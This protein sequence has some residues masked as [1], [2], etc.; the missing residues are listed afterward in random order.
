M[1]AYPRRLQRWVQMLVD[2]EVQE[3]VL[4]NRPWPRDMLL[5]AELLAAATLTRLFLGFWKFP[6]TSTLPRGGA[7]A[8][9]PNLRELV[10]SSMDIESRD[11]DFL[12]TESPALEKLGIQSRIYNKGIRLRLVGQR[13]RCVQVHVSAVESITVVD[14]PCLE[15][16]FLSGSRTHDGSFVR[17]KIGN[18]PKLRLLGY[19]EPGTHMLEIGNSVINF[20]GT[21]SNLRTMAPNVKILGLYVRFG[22]HNDVKM[23]PAFLRC[24]PNVETLHIMSGKTEETTGKLNLKFWQEAGPIESI[25]SHIKTMIFREFQGG[26]SEAA[27]LKF[28]FQTAQVL[29][30]AVIVGAKGS[31]TSIPEVI[32]KVQTLTPENWGS[33]CSVHISKSSGLVGGELFCLRAGF[34]FSIS[35]PFRYYDS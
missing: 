5:P 14:A 17:V 24:F 19:L 13:L 15:R 4:V 16:L 11:L 7:A 2:K 22:V 20:A 9:F 12:L 33:N 35:D 34:E 25:R 30:N 23:L 32:R 29:K 6:D 18:A 21:S 10:L 1:G 28:M 27:F 8:A 26:P 31:F 3:L